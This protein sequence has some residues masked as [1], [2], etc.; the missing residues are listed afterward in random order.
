MDKNKW[1]NKDRLG[2]YAKAAVAAGM[3]GLMIYGAW[4][5]YYPTQ[6]ALVQAMPHKDKP[7][8]M[9]QTKTIAGVG[10]MFTRTLHADAIVDCIEVKRP[11]EVKE[12]QPYIACNI[13]RNPYGSE[14]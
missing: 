2:D 8:D 6:Q 7:K 13:W 10:Y 12:T 11:K 14:E 1:L 4:Q 5:A 9:Q 3:V